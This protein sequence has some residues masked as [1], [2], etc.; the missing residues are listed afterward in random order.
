MTPD[1]SWAWA[2]EPDIPTS[3]ADAGQVLRPGRTRP[4][5]GPV[6]AALHGRSVGHAAIAI[7]PPGILQPVGYRRQFCSRVEGIADLATRY[8]QNA[9]GP[10]HLAQPS[11]AVDPFKYALPYSR[12]A[13]AWHRSL[14][15]GLNIWT[16]VARWGVLRRLPVLLA[17]CAGPG[18]GIRCYLPQPW[19]QR[20][21]SRSR[22]LDK[23]VLI[24]HCWSP[25]GWRQI[26]SWLRHHHALPS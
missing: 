1:A 9:R 25:M 22:R 3:L 8:L 14:R 6:A 4:G 17:A 16:M 23:G 21:G 11:I 24:P 7:S 10:L 19:T 18:P 2:S 12:P 15:R 26:F 5:N 13:P 20:T